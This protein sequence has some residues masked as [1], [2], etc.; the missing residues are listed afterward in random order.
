MTSAT[1]LFGRI[2]PKGLHFERARC[3]RPAAAEWFH[4]ARD[5]MSMEIKAPIYGI[6]ELPPPEI[7][8]LAGQGW[9]G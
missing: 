1:Y 2:N 4:I 6:T 5:T 7:M 3:D 8:A 9:L